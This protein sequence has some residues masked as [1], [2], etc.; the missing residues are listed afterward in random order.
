MYAHEAAANFASTLSFHAS[1][2]LSLLILYIYTYIPTPC[3]L[4]KT[5]N[6][7]LAVAKFIYPVFIPKNKYVRMDI[8]IIF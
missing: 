5:V 2:P 3:S 7:P 1:L 8:L 4:L 6:L